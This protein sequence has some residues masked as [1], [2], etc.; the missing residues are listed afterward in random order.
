MQM[1][2]TRYLLVEY[3]RGTRYTIN[4]C[5]WR[6]LWA[7]FLEHGGG[8]PRLALSSRQFALASSMD[9]SKF[10]VRFTK[11]LYFPEQA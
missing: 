9:L 4:R 7:V 5:V 2:D 3:G 10:F 11:I 8:A 1:Q 6:L